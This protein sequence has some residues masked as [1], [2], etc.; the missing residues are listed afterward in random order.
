M[1]WGKGITIALVLFISFIMYMVVNMMSTKIDLESEDYYQKE[2]NYS[3]ELKA[4]NR[5]NNFEGRPEISLTE[6]H[7][8][9]QLPNEIKLFDVQLT[10]RR[11]NDDTL[12]KSFLIVGTKTFTIDKTNLVSGNYQA[13]LSFEIE[14]ELYIQKQNIII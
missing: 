14:G 4:I 11:P 6:T 3:S 10:L 5:A 13:V 1:N 12:D 7:L 2:I 8:I 9:I